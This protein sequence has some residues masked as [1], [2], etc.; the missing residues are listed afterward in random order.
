ME[1]LMSVRS[2][3]RAS[4]VGAGVAALAVVAVAP[5][6]YA[7][8]TDS[9][10]VQTPGWYWQ[11][12]ANDGVAISELTSYFED[13]QGTGVPLY[14]WT[15]DGFDGFLQNGGSFEYTGYASVSISLNP[16]SES[17]VNNGLTS[18]VG[19]QDI[20]FGDGITFTVTST[21]EIQGS[22]VRW[23]FDVENT[24]AGNEA[25]LTYQISGNLG[26]DDETVWEAGGPGE[27]VSYQTQA[28]GYWVD[29]VFG[30]KL[31]TPGTAAMSVA[32]TNDSPDIAG[33]GDFVLTLAAVEWDVCSLDA[34]RAGMAAA[35]PT[36]DAT[37]GA[38]LP[39]YYT[40]NC[41]AL[42]SP[43]SAQPGAAIDYSIALDGLPAEF[44]PSFDLVDADYLDDMGVIVKSAPAGVTV[45]L[46]Y[47]GGGNPYLHV[48]G[49]MPATASTIEVV[50]YS[51]YGGEGPAIEGAWP[52]MSTFSLS[53]AL[54]ETGTQESTPWIAGSAVFLLLSGAM[55]LVWRSRRA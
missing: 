10:D 38:S 29:P 40:T 2:K 34:A 3:V 55:L 32:D 12:V 54:A 24:G 5:A 39:E 48:V 17:Y 35:V 27:Y 33:S 44:A 20:D 21:M 15:D 11:S 47:D 4:V 13:F 45:T 25:D 41:W 16:V 50:L 26:S 37:F 19:S 51:M 23:T 49:T 46:E 9:Q 52:F 31:T 14:G 43:A 53:P 7:A 22:Y 8:A 18:I 30:W 1:Q 36:L 6:A 42:T 28:S